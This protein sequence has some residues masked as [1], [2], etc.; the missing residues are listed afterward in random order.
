MDKQLEQQ[1]KELQQRVAELEGSVQG[2]PAKKSTWLIHVKPGFDLEKV[3]RDFNTRFNI[4][5]KLRQCLY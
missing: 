1:V 5:T 3:N 2:Q 4:N